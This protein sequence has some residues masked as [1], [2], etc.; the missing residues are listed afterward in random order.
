LEWIT[1]RHEPFFSNSEDAE[2]YVSRELPAAVPEG[3]EITRAAETRLTWVI[4][5]TELEAGEW[6]IQEYLVRIS[7]GLDFFIFTHG[8]RDWGVFG[9]H[10]ALQNAL[11]IEAAML[12]AFSLAECLRFLFSECKPNEWGYT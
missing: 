7:I 2:A 10:H 6:P 8:N 12:R 1:R 3:W 11:V 5:K 4:K 9:L